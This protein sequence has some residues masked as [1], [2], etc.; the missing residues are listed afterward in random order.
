MKKVILTAFVFTTLFM[1][2]CSNKEDAV[3]S[4][5]SIF[6]NDAELDTTWINE[7]FTQEFS[8]AHSGIKVSVT[9]SVMPFSLGFH[10]KFGSISNKKI[11]SVNISVWIYVDADQPIKDLSLVASIDDKAKNIFWYG[12]PVNSKVKENKKWIF[13][14]EQIPFDKNIEQHT[15]Y[16]FTGYVLNNSKIRVLIDDI[17]FRF[18]EE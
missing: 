8:K 2:S 15:N 10:K 6:S 4:D 5:L 12:M 17:S 13:V 9:D 16:T 14:S 7:K 11:K 18:T 3:H 1:S